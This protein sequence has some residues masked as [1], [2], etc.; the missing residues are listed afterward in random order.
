MYWRERLV[1]YQLQFLQCEYP[2]HSQVDERHL[3]QNAQHHVVKKKVGYLQL[4]LH[5]LVVKQL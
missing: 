5:L 3:E 1:G 2:A 4:Y